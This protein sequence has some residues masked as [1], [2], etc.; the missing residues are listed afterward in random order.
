MRKYDVAI[1]VAVEEKHIAEAIAVELKK[2]RVRCFFYEEPHEDINSWGKSLIELTVDNYGKRT[3]YV[4]LI[5]SKTFVEKYW[6]KIETQVA[7]S[8]PQRGNILQ[9]RLDDTPVDGISKHVVHRDWNNNPVEIA[10]ILREKVRRKK[11]LFWRRCVRISTFLSILS[12]IA[13]GWEILLGVNNG[14]EKRILVKG[15]TDKFYIS[16]VEVTV[17]A[18]REYCRKTGRMF[19]EQPVNAPENGPVSN[20]T[21]EEAKAYCEYMKGRLPLKVEWETAA[22]AGKGTKYSGGTAAGTVGVYRRAKPA[23]IGSRMANEWGIYDM[24]GNVAE[25]CDDWADSLK[26]M[27]LVKGGGY[28]NDTVEGLAVRDNRSEKPGERLPDVGFRVVWDKE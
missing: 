26:T 21:W 1:S 19:P 5:T 8:Q 3:N 12:I 7:L 14:I 10:R 25:W 20:V 17:A 9:L 4:L 18:Y 22:L 15:A 16:S 27:K 24:T 11:K 2:F 23:E 6:S 28:M 13:G